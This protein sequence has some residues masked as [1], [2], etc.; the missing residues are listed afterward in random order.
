[1]SWSQKLRNL[2]ILLSR[3]S[4]IHWSPLAFELF[5][6]MDALVQSRSALTSA[7]KQQTGLIPAV[8]V[9]ESGETVVVEAPMPGI[10]PK[11]IELS[12]DRGVLTIKAMSERRTEVEE[13]TYYRKEVRHGAVFRRIPLPT[14]V[15]EDRADAR[16]EQG[17]IKISFPKRS[18]TGTAIK[19]D[20]KAS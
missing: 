7:Q 6:D 2:F 12:V 1:M 8:D 20:I 9:Y 13:A 15:I 3:M 17:I 14:P 16:Y 5:D 11:N 4:L 10:D 18:S 19:L